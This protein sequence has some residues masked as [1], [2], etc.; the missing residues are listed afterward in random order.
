MVD[1]LRINGKLL[2][3]GIQIETN[4]VLIDMYARARYQPLWQEP[5]T[6]RKL[7]AE[8]EQ[9][10]LDGLEPEDYHFCVLSSTGS[11]TEA[12]SNTPSE[13]AERDLVLSDA[14]IRLSFHLYYGKVDPRAQNSRWP[15]PAYIGKQKAAALLIRQITTG[16][17]DA[18]IDRMRPRHPLY[19]RLVTALSRYYRVADEGGWPEIPAGPLI[20]RGD[21]D[22][23]VLLIRQRLMATGDLSLTSVDHADFFDEDL[24]N[25]TARFQDRHRI[26]TFSPGS[27]DC[28][29]AVGEDTREQMNVPVTHRIDQ[30]R[31]N[32]E[33][34]RWVLHHL[35]ST[36]LIA[37]IADFSVVLVQEDQVVWRTRAQVGDA[38]RKTPV[39]RSKIRYMEI[40]PS[41][42]VPPGIL[43]SSLLPGL[44]KNPYGKL[45]ERYVVYDRNG[46]PVGDPAKIPW[47][48][49]TG[50]TLPYRLVQRPGPDNPMGQIKFIF[51]NPDFVFIHDTPNR[52]FFDLERRDLSAGCIRIEKPFELAV[53]LMRL[54]GQEGE[55]RFQT[56]L[57]S[58]LT[59][60]I[61]L[62]DPFP[63]ILFYGTVSVDAKGEVAFR[64]DIYERDKDLLESLNAPAGLW[65]KTARQ[66]P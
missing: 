27:D 3:L 22:P 11:S 34:A 28:Y 4:R 58:G 17:I 6:V 48:Q 7:I 30:I 19:R 14:L 52:D 50:R 60:R 41:W 31:V 12:G 66:V 38:Y 47:D 9:S 10:R 15:L 18:F 23:R 1:K 26:D 43:D 46:K 54:D 25:A 24:V 51:P 5:S 62:N 40:N 13:T 20:E 42:T 21:R 36:Y 37:D 64:P 44:G 56:L 57:G 33:R 55:N 8:I 35:P 63:V 45:L 49:Y 29:G 16:R 61:N 39:F 32:L 2:A 53:I 59:E 65:R